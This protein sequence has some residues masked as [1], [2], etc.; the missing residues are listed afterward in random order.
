MRKYTRTVYGAAMTTA[1]KLGIPYAPE[2]N[3]TLN[4]KF[5]I[6]AG[7]APD[8]ATETHSI[9]YYVIGNGGH[10]AI[11][12]ADGFTFV[13][14]H[15]HQPTDAVCFQHIP[16]VLR[17]VTSDLTTEERAK[18]ALRRE[19]THNGQ[20]YYAYYARRI[21]YSNTSVNMKTTSVVNGVSTSTTFTPTSANLNP[22]PLVVA[23]GNEVILSSSEY[24]SA[25][26]VTTITFDATDAAELRNVASIIYGDENYAVISEIGLVGGIDRT[27]VSGS[28]TYDEVIA[29]IVDTFV[30]TYYQLTTS[31]NGFQFVADV[32]ITE[33]LLTTS[34]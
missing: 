21:D 11:S 18:Y 17:P 5:G 16:F 10:S 31:T 34:V 2:A 26:A 23:D 24:V 20:N 33:P 12:G 4:E 6:Q 28:V 25:S 27:V 13:T 22:T 14:S 30:S 32:G 29:G 15:N 19:E 1:L 3:S 7:A 9:G 8:P